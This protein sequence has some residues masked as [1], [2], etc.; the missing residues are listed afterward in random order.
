MVTR[1]VLAVAGEVLVDGVVHDLENTVVQAA[2]IG[3]ADI[4]S[5][6][7]AHGLKAFEFLDL[8]GTIRLVGGDVGGAVEVGDFV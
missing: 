7:F 8:I 5:G 2:L 3:V 4:H 1:D 6:P